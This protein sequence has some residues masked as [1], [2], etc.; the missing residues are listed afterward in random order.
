MAA[1][2]RAKDLKE[3]EVVRVHRG[4][5]GG[6]SAGTMSQGLQELKPKVQRESSSGPR[7]PASQ[8]LLPTPHPLHMLSREPETGWDGG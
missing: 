5:W 1:P 3:G 8:A 6:L 7:Y 2:E 4:G